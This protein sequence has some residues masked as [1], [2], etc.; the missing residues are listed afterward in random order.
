ME[1]LDKTD[2]SLLSKINSLQTDNAQSLANIRQ[3]LDNKLAENNKNWE[4][5]HDSMVS[6]THI[7]IN[8]W[9]K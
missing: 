4:V 2:D 9:K 8:I 1:G 7:F 3:D 5:K 6:E